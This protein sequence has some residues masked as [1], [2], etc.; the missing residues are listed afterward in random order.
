MNHTPGPWH[1]DEGEDEDMPELVAQS[2]R[3]CWFGNDTQYYPTAGDPPN[4]ADSRLIAAAPDMLNAL[5]KAVI[6]LAGACVHSPELKPQAT[7]DDVSAAI[8]KAIGAANV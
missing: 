3:V 1:W 7:Y 5:R 4:K 8:A 6:L 2:G